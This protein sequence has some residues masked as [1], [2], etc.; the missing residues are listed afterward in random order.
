MSRLLLTISRFPN[1][2]SG[3]SKLLT[4][5]GSPLTSHFKLQNCLKSTSAASVEKRH[6]SETFLTGASSLYAEQMYEH[7]CEDPNSVHETWRKYF[8]DME[9]GIAYDEG[10]FNRPTVVVSNQK[11][12]VD[13][14]TSHLA[15]SD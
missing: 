4:R 10:S 11:K 9:R 12:T 14:S 2:S 6:E 1:K 15:V 13:A 7:W 8:E 3:P 5:S